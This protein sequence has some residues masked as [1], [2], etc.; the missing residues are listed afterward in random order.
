MSDEKAQLGY[1]KLPTAVCTG[2][3]LEKLCRNELAVYL[4]IAAYIDGS[5]W[6]A[7]PSVATIA[8]AAGC[9]RRTVQRSVAKL[10]KRGLIRV[11]TGGGRKGPNVYR[12]TTEWITEGADGDGGGRQ[13]CDAGGGVKSVARGG[14]QNDFEGASKPT[15][16][17]VKTSPRGRQAHDTR[18]AQQQEQQN[19]RGTAAGASDENGRPEKNN[20]HLRSTLVAAG[21]GEPTLSQLAAE[22]RLTVGIVQDIAGESRSRGKGPGIIIENIRT[23]LEAAEADRQGRQREKNAAADAKAK[24]VA[25]ESKARRTEEKAERWIA[26]ETDQAVMLLWARLVEEHPET[27]PPAIRNGTFTATQ[28]RAGFASDLFSRYAEQ[29]TGVET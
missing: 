1:G 28:I 6:D 8:R 12:L 2:G 7:W 15:G 21:I 29:S 13:S 3:A 18:T 22:P 26:G 20:G 14:R 11:T 17:G 10:E 9:T 23:A 4:Q 27:V 19:S 16:G 5:S 24:E 25:A